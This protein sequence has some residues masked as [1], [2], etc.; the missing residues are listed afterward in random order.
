MLEARQLACCKPRLHARRCSRRG[1]ATP[2]APAP[3]PCDL[4]HP[5]S[6][7]VPPPEKAAKT[8]FAG[9]GVSVYVYGEGDLVS[10]WLKDVQSWEQ[11]VRGRRPRRADQ[12][13]V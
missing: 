4:A 13:A 2:H 8:Q 6:A 1:A 11:K 7:K 10:A 3:A 12:G 9:T 5:R